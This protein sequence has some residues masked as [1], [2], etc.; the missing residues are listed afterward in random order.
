MST[1]VKVLMYFLLVNFIA[2]FDYS[3]K[4]AIQQK[5][6][7]YKETNKSTTNKS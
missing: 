7:F 1:I 3:L 2:D 4:F 5:C 6:K